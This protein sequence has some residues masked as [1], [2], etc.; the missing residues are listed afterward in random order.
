MHPYSHLV[1]FHQV[2]RIYLSSSFKQ[3]ILKEKW[4]KV[5]WREHIFKSHIPFSFVV[6]FTVTYL[7]MR[8]K[9]LKEFES[10]F[11]SPYKNNIVTVLC[12][13]V[14]VIIMLRKHS[15]PKWSTLGL[16]YKELWR[17]SVYEWCQEWKPQQD[18]PSGTVYFLPC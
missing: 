8:F 16:W 6:C 14:C 15:L 10:W 18:R 17:Q 11:L 4:K 13:Y 1:T 2:K 7:E 9:K 5:R 12:V 3:I